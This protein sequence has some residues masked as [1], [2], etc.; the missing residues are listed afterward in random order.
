[1]EFGSREAKIFANSQAKVHA[2]NHRFRLLY[3]YIINTCSANGLELARVQAPMTSNNRKLNNS[4]LFSSGNDYYY[5][6]YLL[7]HI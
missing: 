3:V 1:M 5:Y 2:N 4:K 7:F 6:Y